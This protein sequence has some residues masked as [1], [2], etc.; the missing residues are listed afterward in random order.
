[1]RAGAAPWG[2]RGSWPAPVRRLPSTGP[3]RAPS[4]SA[5]S[6]SLTRWT[7]PACL[8]ALA[9]TPRSTEPAPSE[10]WVVFDAMPVWHSSCLRGYGVSTTPCRPREPKAEAGPVV[11][12]LWMEEGQ[13]SEQRGQNVGQGRLLVGSLPWDTGL[14]GEAGRQGT[15]ASLCPS[16][17]QH[18]PGQALLGLGHGLPFTLSTG[19]GH[20]FWMF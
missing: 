11:P 2:L 1:M 4:L 15:E 16:R 5:A 20:L 9:C 7:S 6:V 12:R 10:V 18:Q 14:S 17:L 3:G 8:P 19:L 13:D